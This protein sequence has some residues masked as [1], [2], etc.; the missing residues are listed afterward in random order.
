MQDASVIEELVRSRRIEKVLSKGSGE[1]EAVKALQEVL[2][3]LGYDGPLRWDTYGADGDYGRSTS[4]AVRA[5]AL[6]QGIDVDG[7]R[8]TPAIA[9]ALTT[10]LAAANAQVSGEGAEQAA[11]RVELGSAVLGRSDSGPEVVEL[12]IRLAGFR[13]TVWDGDFGPG[14]ELQVLAF[15][16]DYMRMSDPTGRA[17]ENIYEALRRFAEDYPV[18]FE[19][20]KCPC[21]ECGGFGQGRFANEYRDGYPEIEAYH[22]REYPGIHKATLHTFRAARFY[23][24]LSE[25]L[26]LDLTCGYR[27]WINN[28][29]KGRQST[30]HMGKALDCDFPGQPEEDKRDDLNRCDRLRGQ[31]VEKSNFQ[32][33]WGASNRK[34][35][36][37]SSIAPTWIHMDVRQYSRRY[38]ADRFFVT[39]AEQLDSFSG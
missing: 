7:S 15:Q 26:A 13:G 29:R 11:T 9:E 14:T 8:V 25:E 12:Q 28:D 30:N 31:L 6:D 5:F 16:R 18:D 27:C 37:P 39:S 33:G 20:L 3:E 24:S 23:G 2:H 36:E 34:S 21:G 19:Q 10:A 22:R 38:L 17:D 32:I 4:R 1:K 35:L